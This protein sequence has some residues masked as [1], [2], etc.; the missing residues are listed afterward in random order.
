V[1]VSEEASPVALKAAEA[2][3]PDLERSCMT[4][5]ER[6]QQEGRLEG[7]LEGEAAALLKLVTL[8]FGAPSAE[9]EARVRSATK[10]ELDTWVER[11]LTASSLAE[12]FVD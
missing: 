6:L 12:L 9:T 10:A 7:R 3:D 4:L 11:I 8:K 1:E 2:A 5:Y